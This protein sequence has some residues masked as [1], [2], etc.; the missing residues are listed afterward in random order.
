[1][2]NKVSKSVLRMT[3]LA[4]LAAVTVVLQ[5]AG[6][7]IH[8]GPF[9]VSLVLLPIVLG[10]VIG[11]PVGGG[12]LGL[13]FGVTVLLSGDAA[14][15][16]GINPIGTVL[17]VLIKGIL[18]GAVAGWLYNLIAKRNAIIA[19]FAAAVVCPVVNTG[20][21]LIG[22]RLFFMSWLSEQ[23]AAEGVS[24]LTY[25]F[26]FLV[27]GNFLFEFLV[28]LV[29]CPLLSRLIALLPSALREK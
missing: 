19:S 15:F 8:L 22:C 21:F 5:L 24:S 16:L 18:A 2:K 4:M 11:G 13:V 23:A 25:A 14:L 12:W 9:S 17:T 28:N 6:S 7:F 26:L 3:Y 20:M 10:A 27:G 1:M 29:L